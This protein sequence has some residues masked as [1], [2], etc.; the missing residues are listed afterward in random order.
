M[1]A[2]KKKIF[3]KKRQQPGNFVLNTHRT[4]QSKR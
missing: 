4:G 3:K 1:E 2:A